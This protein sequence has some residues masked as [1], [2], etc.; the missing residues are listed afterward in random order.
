MWTSGLIKEQAD[1]IDNYRLLTSRKVT[2]LTCIGRTEIYRLMKEE[3][4]PRP[5]TLRKRTGHW[6]ESEVKEWIKRRIRARTI[7][8]TLEPS[9]KTNVNYQSS[10]GR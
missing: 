9:T 8:P 3:D 6:L 5:V 1:P 4:F 7:P 2:E 10:V